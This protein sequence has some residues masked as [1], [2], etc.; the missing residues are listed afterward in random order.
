MLLKVVGRG[1]PDVS[2]R[3]HIA[4]TKLP[5]DLKIEK[6]SRQAYFGPAHGWLETHVLNRSDLRKPQE[7][8][9]IVE[10]YDSTCV[11]PP[12]CTAQLDGFG[13]MQ[14]AVPAASAALPGVESEKPASAT[15]P[16]LQDAAG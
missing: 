15:T 11:I 4:K 16:Q 13:N 12:G 14:I 6:P 1:I 10:E 9:C 3:D 7:G 5:A 8:P 2:R